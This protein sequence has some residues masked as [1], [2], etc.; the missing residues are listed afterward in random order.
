MISIVMPT[1]NRGRYLKQNYQAIKRTFDRVKLPF[2][3]ILVNDGSTDSTKSIIE[4]L[5]K[6]YPAV[7]AIS[8]PNNQGQQRATL[9]G[10]AAAQYD[11]VA[12]LDDD[13]RCLPINIYRMYQYL[14]KYNYDIVYGV[15]SAEASFHWRKWGS[16]LKEKVFQWC[17]GKP[18]HL[19]VTSIRIMTKPLVDFVI[20]DW[21]KQVYLSARVLEKT[22][23]IGNIRL[24]GE[25]KEK[26][27]TGKLHQTG[28]N[29]TFLMR[30]KLFLDL[31]WY[32]RIKKP[33]SKWKEAHNQRR[34]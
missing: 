5:A 14:R 22:R 29:Y 21:R 12:T 1:Y 17:L 28:S 2:E 32:Y 7:Q 26:F 10:L 19:K 8:L 33:P 31:I 16:H 4:H 30:L 9:I 11:Y 25:P 34:R 27:G 6:K 15:A 3:L 20:A 24:I 18:K 13:G 23:N